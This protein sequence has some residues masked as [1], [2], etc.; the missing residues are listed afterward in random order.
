MLWSFGHV[1][2]KVKVGNSEIYDITNLGQTVTLNILTN[3]SRSNDK[4]AMKFCQFIEYNK[5]NIFL[6]K[7]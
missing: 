4:Q 3:I 6:E 7:S 1:E 5:K 2:K